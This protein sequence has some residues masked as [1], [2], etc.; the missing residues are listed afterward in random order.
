[1]GKVYLRKKGSKLL[2]SNRI[3]RVEL[4]PEQ[5]EDQKNAPSVD[6]IPVSRVFGKDSDAKLAHKIRSRW[7]ET[8]WQLKEKALAEGLL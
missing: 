2:K 3:V 6:Q 7:P 8:Y 1:M 4:T 5:L